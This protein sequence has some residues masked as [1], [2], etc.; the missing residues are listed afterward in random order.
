MKLSKLLES[1]GCGMP[2]DASD[3]RITDIVYHSGQAGNGSLFACIR[4]V[5]ADGHHFA[6]EAAARGAAAVLCEEPVQLPACCGGNGG[7]S[8]GDA[9][10]AEPEGKQSLWHRKDPGPAVIRVPDTRKALAAVSAAFYG[11]PAEEMIIIGVT[12][13]KGKTS[14]CFM[15]QSV[16]TAAGIKCGL[17]GTVYIDTGVRKL[18]SDRTTPE[19][20]EIHKFL[21]EMAEAGCRVAVIEVSS[22]ALKLSKT[23]G[24]LFDIAVFTNLEEDHIGA[25]EH[26]NFAEYAACKG[27]LF[28]Q[29]KIAVV[30]GDDPNRR[31]VLSGCTAQIVSYGFSGGCD[32]CIENPEYVKL[33]D[34]LGMEFV[35]KGSYN[36]KLAVGSAGLFSCSNAAACAAVCRELGISDDAVSEG[37]RTVSIPGRQEIFPV[38]QG[39]LI[40]VD[41]AHNGMALSRLLSSLRKYNPSRLTCIFGCGGQRDPAR[42]IKMA[43]AAAEYADFTVITSDNPRA[44]PPEDIIRD[45]ALVLIERGCE[46]AVI[47]DRRRA[48]DRS[49]SQ[50]ACGEI[51]VIAGKGHETYQLIGDKKIY[52]DDRAEVL[53]SI[54]KVKNEQN[55]FK[56]N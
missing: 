14:T 49:I 43:Q 28:T 2:E 35:L 24:I 34:K 54:E 38:G 39:K 56:R 52:F 8:A 51:A 15:I 19:A 55:N 30:N 26:E 45:I 6:E 32:F 23:D 27:K 20:P 1:S 12:G 48:I 40:M 41:Y 47:P 46:F 25:G 44:E 16:L 22:Q 53:S 7:E 36:I 21:R 4:G 18:D 10:G 37:L 9:K 50:C 3:C 29:C 5:R 31:L 33:P 17:V 42:R 13:T 11:F